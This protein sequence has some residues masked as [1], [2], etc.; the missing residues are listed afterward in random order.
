M[1]P[2]I[3]LAI[4]HNQGTNS[5]VT[6]LWAAAANAPGIELCSWHVSSK[7]VFGTDEILTSIDVL[8]ERQRSEL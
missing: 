1:S 2:K 3:D 7:G 8:S 4:A 5:A 6:S